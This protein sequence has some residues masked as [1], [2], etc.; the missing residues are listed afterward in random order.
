MRS[1]LTIYAQETTYSANCEEYYAVIIFQPA[2][3][4]ERYP[5]QE[6][7]EA[8]VGHLPIGDHEYD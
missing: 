3:H 8:V 5:A 7:S 4:L 1:Y 6:R 2:S